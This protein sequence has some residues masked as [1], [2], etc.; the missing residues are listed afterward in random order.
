MLLLSLL[1]A[2]E[3]CC[4][5]IDE[6]HMIA[7]PDRGPVLEM[8]LVKVLHNARSIDPA[9]RPQIIGM[10]ATSEAKAAVLHTVLR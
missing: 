9:R 6:L 5:V 1:R 3:L 4:I 7:D 2:G 8:M 10:S